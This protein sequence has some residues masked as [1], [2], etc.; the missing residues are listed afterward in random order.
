MENF[1]YKHPVLA[2]LFLP[3]IFI[4]TMQLVFGP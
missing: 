4:V 2:F 3:V 1:A